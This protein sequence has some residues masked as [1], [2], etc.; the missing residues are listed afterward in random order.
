MM[1]PMII[2]LPIENDDDREF[3]TRIYLD[4]RRLMFSVAIEI[5]KDPL[6]AED[7]VS[8]AVLEMIERI[9]VLRKVNSCRLRSYIASIVRNDSIDYV[10]KR[11]RQGKYC[12]FS[13][14]E[15]LIDNIAEEG[16]LEDEI[17]RR[18][19]G[20]MLYEG[21]AKLSESERLLLTMKYIDDVP[22]KEIARLLGIGNDSVRSYLSR[23]RRHLKQIIMEEEENG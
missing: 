3:L 12:V 4:Y 6:V 7:I 10:R 9:D 22:N 18:V 11:N 8:M 5:V 1:T 16:T 21:I 23:A 2:L 20:E 13:E 15:P 14:D 17:I 19:E